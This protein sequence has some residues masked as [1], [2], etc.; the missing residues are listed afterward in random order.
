LG[1]LDDSI[2]EPKWECNE[3]RANVEGTIRLVCILSETL[4]VSAHKSSGPGEIINSLSQRRRAAAVG[5]FGS[6]RAVSQ[7]HLAQNTE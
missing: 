1:G 3:F 6:S 7:K 2:N 5:K 4:Y